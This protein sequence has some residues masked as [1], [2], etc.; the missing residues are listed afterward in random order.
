VRSQNKSSGKLLVVSAKIIESGINTG[1]DVSRIKCAGLKYSG[2]VAT[3]RKVFR[4]ATANPDV[5][6]PL[7]TE[8]VE[9]KNPCHINPA[10]KEAYAQK[11]HEFEDTEDS[12][13]DLEMFRTILE[14]AAEPEAAEPDE[15]LAT[16]LFP[17]HKPTVMLEPGFE[18]KL[19][20][21]VFE[22]ENGIKY[23]FIPNW[24]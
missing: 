9:I 18:Q 14:E 20:E 4:S 23:P 16:T 5:V 12:L 22:Q 21:E 13:G 10:V 3:G 15:E 6:P 24:M 1:I 2:K 17:S 19:Q 8:A 11:T 7:A